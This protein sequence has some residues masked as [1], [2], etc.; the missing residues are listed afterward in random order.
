VTTNTKTMSE[1]LE[2]Q[3]IDI[4]SKGDESVGIFSSMWTIEQPVF[5][6]PE[7]LETFRNELKAAWEYIADDARVYFTINGKSEF[8]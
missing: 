3:K 5:I 8:I 4:Y 7:D 6:D 2:I 1:Q